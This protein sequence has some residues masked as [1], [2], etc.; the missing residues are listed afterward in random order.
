MMVGWT[1]AI[2]SVS[3]MNAKGITIGEMTSAS[4]EETFDGLPLMVMMRRALEAATLDEA[5]QSI[6]RAPRTTGWNFIIGDAKIP[7]GRALEVDA[8]DCCVFAPKDP[9]EGPGTAS[10]SME[11]AVRRTNHP[12]GMTHIVKLVDRYGPQFGIDRD[13]LEA[14]IPLL[15]MQ[16]TWQ[17]YDWLGKQIQARPKKIDVPEALQLL[18]NGPVKNDATLHSWVFDPKNQVAYVAI[19]GNNPPVTATSRTYTR[20]DLKPWFK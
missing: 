16:N 11:D 10:W 14:A 8:K 9:N 19:A 12:C 1:G 20:I 3:G 17:R 6:Q 18:S 2:G 5:V 15:Q 4:T 13:H 7:D